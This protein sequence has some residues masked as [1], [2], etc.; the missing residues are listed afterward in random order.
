M[1]STYVFHYCQSSKLTYP[2]PIQSNSSAIELNRTPIVRLLNSIEHN[3]THNKI[4]PI[5][6][7]RTFDYRTIGI[8]ERSI[9]ERRIA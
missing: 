8:I 5:E 7:N 2:Q 9:N 1:I 3:R 6:H 4:L